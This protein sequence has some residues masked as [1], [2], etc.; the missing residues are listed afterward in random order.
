MLASQ[1]F[2]PDAHVLHTFTHVHHQVRVLT[3]P[4]CCKTS[5][6]S[7]MARFCC[8]RPL[9]SL[10]SLSCC[11]TSPVAEVDTSVI[12]IAVSSQAE[13]SQLSDWDSA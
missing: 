12:N 13:Q 8:G 6:R 2:E 3:S 7:V 10:A 9:I 11:Q 1:Q 5:A 4:P